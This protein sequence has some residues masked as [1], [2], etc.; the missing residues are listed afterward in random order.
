MR[1]GWRVVG[2]R[3]NTRDD[4]SLYVLLIGSLEKTDVCGFL[5]MVCSLLFIGI[6]HYLRESLIFGWCVS[7]L[8]IAI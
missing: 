7:S 8:L 2:E 3:S 1:I 6:N 4:G 5:K